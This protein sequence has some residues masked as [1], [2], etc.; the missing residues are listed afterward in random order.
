VSKITYHV[1]RHICTQE[2]DENLILFFSQQKKCRW[3]GHLIWN[4]FKKPTTEINL[5][6][7]YLFVN[8]PKWISYLEWL[9]LWSVSIVWSSIYYKTQCLRLALSKG[10]NRVDV[11]RPSPQNG[12]KPGF[13]NITFYSYLEFQM[14]DK[15][16]KPSDSKSEPARFYMNLLGPDS[17]A[18][19]RRKH[20][21]PWLHGR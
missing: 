4:S 18:A 17:S 19:T 12:N 16:H 8:Y 9:G 3:K 10:H 13:R 1:D 2:R 20:G 6:W 11:S 5:K 21:P 15:V 14:M 7:M